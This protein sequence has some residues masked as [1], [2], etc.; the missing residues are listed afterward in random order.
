MQSKQYFTKIKNY[1][2]EK[3][4]EP[5]YTDKIKKERGCAPSFLPYNPRNRELRQGLSHEYYSA[6]KVKRLKA[7]ICNSGSISFSTSLTVFLPSI[8][9]SWFNKQ[10]SFKNLPKR[11]LAMF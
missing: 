2:H 3:S 7:T 10:T 4:T 1:P 6:R 11:P 9:S 5:I 8:M